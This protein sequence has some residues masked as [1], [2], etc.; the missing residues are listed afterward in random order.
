M[1]FSCWDNGDNHSHIGAA[2][3]PMGS[4]PDEDG[5][6]LGG[7]NGLGEMDGLDEMDW[8]TRTHGWLVIWNGIMMVD[9]G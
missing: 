4:S 8:V 1:F 5:Q 9:D 6:L 3:D 2:Q 7:R